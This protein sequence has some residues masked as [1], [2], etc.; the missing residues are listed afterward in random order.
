M[1]MKS[2]CIAL[3]SRS[4]NVADM[5]HQAARVE[6]VVEGVRNLLLA[7]DAR[8]KAPMITSRRLEELLGGISPNTLFQRLEKGVYPRSDMRNGAAKAKNARRLHSLEHVREILRIE[9]LALHKPPG[10]KAQVLTFTNSKGGVGKTTMAV[11]MAQRAARLGADVLL[12]DL[13]PQGSATTLCGF[14]PGAEIESD[15]TMLAAMPHNSHPRHV[16]ELAK[17]TYWPGLDLVPANIALAIA[18]I[19]LPRFIANNPGQANAAHGAVHH[20]L[21][22]ARDMYDLIIIDTPPAV[23][24]LT[25]NALVA[26]DGIIMPTGLSQVDFTATAGFWAM[27]SELGPEIESVQ[28]GKKW[29]FVS[30][31]ANKTRATRSAADSV[32]ELVRQWLQAAFAEKLSTCEIKDTRAVDNAGVLTI[33][34]VYDLDGIGGVDSAEVRVDKRTLD[35]ALCGYD[36]YGAELDGYVRAAWAAAAVLGDDEAERNG[37]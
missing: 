21:A 15:D 3:L 34:T 17:P 20:A 2:N 13:D 22:A 25:L 19:E 18:E 7:P 24:Y 32:G 26:A 28:P 27:V 6:D 9:Q 29:M 36:D 35:R 16:V 1:T 23:G 33:G 8:K 4:L 30:V 5:R 12:I 14:I 10:A 11:S 31:I 37:Q